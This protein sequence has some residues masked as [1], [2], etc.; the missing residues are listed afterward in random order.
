[1]AIQINI[2][3]TILGLLLQPIA[4][5]CF[6]CSTPASLISIPRF[7]RYLNT[8][9]LAMASREARL[10][11][12]YYLA[13]NGT[14]DVFSYDKTVGNGLHTEDEHDD[15]TFFERELLDGYVSHQ[16]LLLDATNDDDLAYFDESITLF[17]EEPQVLK[18][19]SY[20]TTASIASIRNNLPSLVL[21]DV[22]KARLLLVLSA[23]LYGTNFSVVKQLDE[24]IPVAVASTLRFGFASFA[25]MPL[26]LAPMSD[27]FW[28]NIKST[29]NKTTYAFMEP[30][31]LS[32][33]LAGMEIGLWN[34]IGYISQAIGLRT[35]AASTVRRLLFLCLLSCFNDWFL[36]H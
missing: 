5:S 10:K 13:K 17:Y 15:T 3:A 32:V 29:A 25:M 8:N 22:W 30:S 23:A 28:N 34:S 2:K 35:T 27:E 21:S 19:S 6:S 4:L 12:E 14:S 18:T 7:S 31:R 33:G 11:G 1:M 24:I 36:M 26:L 9:S 16:Q 20:T